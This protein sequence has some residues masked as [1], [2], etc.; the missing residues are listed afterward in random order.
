M[1]PYTSA[2]VTG[3]FSVIKHVACYSRNFFIAPYLHRIHL[4]RHI[5][6]RF[7][8]GAWWAIVRCGPVQLW[9]P[10]PAAVP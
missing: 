6:H 1:W 10:A 7:E 3:T 2:A 4:C 8:A 9:P 5:T